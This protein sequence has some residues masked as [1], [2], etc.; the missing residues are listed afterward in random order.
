MKKTL[1]WLIVAIFTFSIAFIGIGCKEEAAPA[2]EEAAPAEEEAA[3][4]EAALEE[5][6]TLEFWLYGGTEDNVVFN[7]GLVDQWNVEHPNIQVNITD[8]LWDTVYEHFQTAA[9]TGTMPDLARVQSP[10]VNAFG[11]KGGYLEPIDN[12]SDFGEVKKIYVK[13]FLDTGYFDGHY[14][15]LPD[16]PIIFTLVGNKELFDEAGI[17]EMPKNWEEFR[18]V[19]KALTKDTDNDGEIDQWGYEMMGAD[20]GGHSYAFAPFVFKAGGGLLNED[21]SKSVVNSEAWIKSVELL[22]E[23]NLEDGSIDPAFLANDFSIMSDNFANGVIAM[24]SG[25]PWWAGV[26]AGKNPDLEMLMGP[27]PGPVEI[28]GDF[29]PG[30]LTDSSTVVISSSSAHKEAAWEFLKFLKGAEAD[31]EYARNASLGGLPIV[32]ATYASVPEWTEIFGHEIYEAEGANARPWPYH[33]DLVEITRDVLAIQTLSAISGKISPDEA[34][35][36]SEEQINEI[37]ER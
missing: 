22:A 27:V 28:L 16:T 23:M 12:F 35:Q 37:L 17:A 31:Q 25:G 13:G 21:W 32:E 1:I 4:E 6:I 19:A 2:E 5:V 34:M 24:C 9:T 18:E 8:Q 20:L 36:V 11:S 29:N 30:T 14:W 3:E 15:G 33:P 10:F 7:H 26:I